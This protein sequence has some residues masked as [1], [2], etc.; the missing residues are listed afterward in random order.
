MGEK[1]EEDRRLKD[2]KD[3]LEEGPET[4]EQDL[5]P[6]RIPYCPH[7]VSVSVVPSKLQS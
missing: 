5:K 1:G 7:H 2:H 6:K 4:S 3:V